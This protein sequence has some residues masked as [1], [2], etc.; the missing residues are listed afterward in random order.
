MAELLFSV[1]V[2]VAELV[3]TA[4]PD[5]FVRGVKLKQF[6]SG[7]T[8]NFTEFILIEKIW[9]KKKTVFDS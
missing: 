3:P 1:A 2:V 9:R 5:G 7:C 4:A 8:S 6:K